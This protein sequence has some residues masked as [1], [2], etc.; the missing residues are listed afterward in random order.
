[1]A[2]TQRRAAEVKFR[3]AGPAD[4]VAVRRLVRAAYAK[5][6]PVIGREPLPMTADYERAVRDHVIDLILV[7][8]EI[9]GL[10]ELVTE[11]DCILIEN[12]AVKPSEWGKSYGQALMSHAVGVAKLLGRRRIR[13]YTNK[14]M[15]QNIALYEKLGYIVD[16]EERTSDGRDAVHMSTTIEAP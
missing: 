12:V 9:V 10:I 16:K 5:W 7:N 15:A 8:G 13:L 4:V 11:P 14:L 1:M 2:K 3:R 6:V